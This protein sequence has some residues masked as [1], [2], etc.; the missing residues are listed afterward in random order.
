MTFIE[1]AQY[2]ANDLTPEKIAEK[3]KVSIRHVNRKITQL[4]ERCLAKTSCG[5]VASY[6]RKKI[7]E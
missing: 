2:L 6:L 4:K 5:A 7:I 1:L 3:E